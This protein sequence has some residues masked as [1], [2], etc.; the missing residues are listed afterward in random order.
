M[1]GGRRGKASGSL[2]M[3]ARRRV[4]FAA[5][6]VSTADPGVATRTGSENATVARHIDHCHTDYPRVVRHRVVRHRVVHHPAGHH[7]IDY[8][9]G[10]I[11][12]GTGIDSEEDIGPRGDT[13]S[14]E[15][16]GFE[17]DIGS[18]TGDSRHLRG[19]SSRRLT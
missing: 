2:V 7:H 3:A 8:V 18:A 5:G 17:V 12:P 13:G 19:R 4:G 6:R 15:D 1:Q 9:Q 14:R 10:D 11:V 16:I